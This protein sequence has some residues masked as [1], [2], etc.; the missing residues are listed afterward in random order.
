MSKLNFSTVQNPSAEFALTHDDQWANVLEVRSSLLR[1]PNELWLRHPLRLT[2][3]L[4]RRHCGF[5]CLKS[6][7][8][9]L[10]LVCGRHCVIFIQVRLT[11]Y[12][13]CFLC[14]KGDAKEQLGCKTSRYIDETDQRSTSLR[15]A[16]NPFDPFCGP[17]ISRRQPPSRSGLYCVSSK[18]EKPAG[19]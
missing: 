6:I 8:S 13:L 3:L 14:R 11:M 10:N 4:T 19:G 9:L 1:C 17:G 5:V 7:T 18:S 16:T 15:H 2:R 12:R